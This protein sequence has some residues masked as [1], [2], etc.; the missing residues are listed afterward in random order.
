MERQPRPVT[1]RELELGEQLSQTDF[2]LR[3]VCSKGTYIRTLCHD[4][5][6]ALGCG[7]T[8]AAL[9]R[10][11]VAGFGLDR[12]VTLEQIQAEADPAALLLPVDGCFAHLPA[13]TLTAAQEKRVRN[14]AAFTWAGAPGQYRAY[15]AGGE[16]LALVQTDGERLTTV[17]SFFDV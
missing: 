10:T 15:G 2:T 9:R 13:L 3:V 16:F 12:A 7:G 4:V 5:G 11:R 14:G 1:I 8:M 6:R 17:K